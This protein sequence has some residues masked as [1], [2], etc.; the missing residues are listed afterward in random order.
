[1]FRMSVKGKEANFDLV[2]MTADS[3][4]GGGMECFCDNPSLLPPKER[5][6]QKLLE[7]NS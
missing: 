1:M 4:L 6:R 3:Q 2:L 7:E 5:L